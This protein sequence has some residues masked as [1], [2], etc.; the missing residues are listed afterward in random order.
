MTVM[1]ADGRTAYIAHEKAIRMTADGRSGLGLR[2]RALVGAAAATLGHELVE[3]G[4]VLGHAQ[5]AE[6]VLK[7]TLLLFEPAQCLG[8]IFI[9]R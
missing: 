8:A 4:L 2:L 6:E 7:I 9:E 5:S 3:L 1:W